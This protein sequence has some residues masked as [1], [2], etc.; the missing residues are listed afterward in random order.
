M[1]GRQLYLTA[2]RRLTQ[3][4]IDSPGG[5]AA[6][7]AQR[8]LGLDR[9]GLAVHGEEDVLPAQEAAFLQAVEE[10]ASRRPLQYI[11]GEWE[12]L[13]LSLSVG[14]GVLCPREDT[15]VLVEEL[16][17]RLKEVP[18]PVGVDL[19]AGTGAVALGLLTRIPQARVQ[20]VELS[21][22]ALPYLEENLRRYGRDQVTAV[23]GDV[24]SRE[25]AAGFAPGSL[26][27]VASNPPYIETGELPTLQPEVQRE[28][29]LALDGGGDGLT[30]YRAIGAL[31]IPALK[32]G[33]VVAVEIGETQARDVAEIFQQSGVTDVEIHP[34]WAGL[35]R[36][37][38]GRK[39]SSP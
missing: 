12:F 23:P 21:E 22:Q 34:D 3:A 38:S 19:C 11:L 36:V 10:R 4:G 30:F 15:A 31:W 35:D 7:L 37:V 1:T 29:S 33:G 13:G 8:F 24:L 6:L 32:P 39:V 2:R 9:T 28:P 16:A 14:E 26:D 5:D 18:A 20:A 25:F 17:S 27:F